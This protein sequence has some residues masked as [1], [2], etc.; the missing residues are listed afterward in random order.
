[1]KLAVADAAGNVA[2]AT[3]HVA[4][5]IRRDGAAIRDLDAYTVAA[6]DP[7]TGSPA[8]ASTTSNSAAG[9]AVAFDLESSA[10]NPFDVA[11]RI[12]FSVAE[13]VHVRLLVYDLTGREVARLVDTPMEPGRHEV[14][15]EAGDLQSGIYLYR[16]EAGAFQ[17]TRRLT[18]AR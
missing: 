5:P 8:V 14:R 6:C 1:M 18:I 4:A 11:T 2:T 10:P 16:M 13:A 15:L 9:P 3:Y 17:A 12:G 7:V